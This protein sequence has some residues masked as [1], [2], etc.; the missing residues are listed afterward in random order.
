MSLNKSYE[1]LNLDLDIGY[2]RNS[3]LKTRN[4]ETS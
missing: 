4:T 3:F 2:Y 1:T